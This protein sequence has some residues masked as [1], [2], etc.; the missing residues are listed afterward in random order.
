LFLSYIKPHNPVTSQRLAHWI[1]EMLGYLLKIFFTLLIGV[2]I[3]HSGDFIIV[4]LRRMFMSRLYCRQELNQREPCLD[5]WCD[6][7]VLLDFVP[8]FMG[9]VQSMYLAFV[10]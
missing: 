10:P 3:P 4:P 8:L 6:Y 5:S 2:Q 1:K 9:L 7:T